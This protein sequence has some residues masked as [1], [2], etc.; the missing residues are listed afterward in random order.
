[1]EAQNSIRGRRVDLLAFVAHR[2]G[3]PGRFHR[4]LVVLDVCVPP[5]RVGENEPDERRSGNEPHD[6]E[7]PVE[8]GVHG[9]VRG[10][11]T[12][13]DTVEGGRFMR[14]PV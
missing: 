7:P 13:G 14:R 11:P 12:R 1:V 5:G 10:A 2:S 3:D 6:Q 8:F 4:N 9:R